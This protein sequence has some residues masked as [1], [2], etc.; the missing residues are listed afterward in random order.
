[1]QAP[2]KQGSFIAQS[3]LGA[4]DLSAGSAVMLGYAAEL[5]REYKAKLR[6]V[7]AVHEAQSQ[8]ERDFSNF[9]RRVGTRG[10]C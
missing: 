7:H 5:A 9:L 6:L 10:A 4:L 2:D 3:I 1:V 8:P